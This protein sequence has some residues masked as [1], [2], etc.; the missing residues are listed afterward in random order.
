[1]SI[2]KNRLQQSRPKPM[3]LNGRSL[4]NCANE[5]IC[6]F[7]FGKQAAYLRRSMFGKVYEVALIILVRSKLRSTAGVHSLQIT[8]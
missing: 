6:P 3:S 5:H 8:K 1:M 7:L 2:F 4:A